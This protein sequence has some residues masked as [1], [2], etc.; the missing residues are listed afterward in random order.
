M[1]IIEAGLEKD[2][3]GKY[4]GLGASQSSVGEFNRMCGNHATVK[5]LNA[6]VDLSDLTDDEIDNLLASME[7]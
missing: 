6:N 3:S 5:T 1:R 7:G 2:D 4:L